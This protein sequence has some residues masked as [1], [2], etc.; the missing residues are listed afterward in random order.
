MPCLSV[1]PMPPRKTVRVALLFYCFSTIRLMTAVRRSLIG[2]V[3]GGL[4]CVVAVS[5][6]AGPYFNSA[7]PRV[8]RPGEVV[9][10]RAGAG[11]RQAG[12]M[13][14]YLVASNRAPAPYPCIWHGEKADCTPM[15]RSAPNA[16]PYIRIGTVDVR[17]AAGS[18]AAGY[19]VTIKFRVPTAAAPGHYAYVLYCTWCASKGKGSLIAWPLVKGPDGTA[20]GGVA[21]SVP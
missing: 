2:L 20:L 14:L 16:P 9:T 8:A 6:A 13:P 19:D 10:L 17:Q 4:A 11:S 7:S 12:T 5:A 18:P 1:R 15:A 3:V 21:L